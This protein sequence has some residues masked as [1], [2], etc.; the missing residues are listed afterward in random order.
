VFLIDHKDFRAARPLRG[1]TRNAAPMVKVDAD[2]EGGIA[3]DRNFFI[4]PSKAHWS[5]DVRRAPM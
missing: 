2:P 5:H 3:L 4:G 1:S